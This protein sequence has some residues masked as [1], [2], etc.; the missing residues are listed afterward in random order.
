VLKPICSTAKYSIS[1]YSFTNNTGIGMWRAGTNI[2]AFSTS[3]IERI[4]V[5][6]NGNVGIGTTAPTNMLNVN[7][8]AG[9]WPLRVQNSS[10]YIDFGPANTSYAHI[11]TDRPTFYLNK[12]L[13]AGAGNALLNASNGSSF[14]NGGN[15]GLGTTTPTQKLD[16]R[17]NIYSSGQ[18]FIQNVAPTIYLQDTDHR[19]GMI[20]MNSNLLYF[21]NGAGVNS[22]TWTP[23][24]STWPLTINMATD[25]ISVGGVMSIGDWGGC[26][27]NYRIRIGDYLSC[28]PVIQP[29]VSFFGYVGTSSSYFW[30]MFSN[31]YYATD[32]FY[33]VSDK[34]F[35]T[36]ISP[37]NNALDKILS[38]KGVSY[39][40]IRGSVIDNGRDTEGLIGR[41]GFL[42]QEIEEVLPSAVRKI[43]VL[44]ETDSGD[45]ISSKSGESYLSVNYSAVIP[46][47]V[48]AIKEQQKLIENL[49][50]R[51]FILESK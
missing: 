45:K 50:E 28:D 47:L 5:L 18:Y 12:G 49:K 11:Y 27:S 29:G 37:I 2:L 7:G 51:I 30:E 17:G 22:T 46:V 1:F 14:I 48:E 34:R 40:V 6:A 20:H 19:S 33:F 10:G 35:K 13:Y 32:G 15:F 26:G 42:A 24:N 3:G 25:D 31:R 36:N 39:D 38:L 4:R 23:I 8:G 9:T 43:D 16:V 44:D 21:L 41:L